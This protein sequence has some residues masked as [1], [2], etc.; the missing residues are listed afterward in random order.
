MVTQLSKGDLA[1]LWLDLVNAYGSITHKLAELALSRYHVP[2]KV[3][4]LILDYYDSFS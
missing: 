2:E 4:K 1:A 3:W